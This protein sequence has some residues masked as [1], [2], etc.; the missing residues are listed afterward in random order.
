MFAKD[1]EEIVLLDQ[2]LAV[3]LERLQALG[4]GELGVSRSERSDRRWLVSVAPSDGPVAYYT[5]DRD[6]GDTTFMFHHREELTSYEL[7]PMEPF[8]FTARDGLE[9][10]GYVTFPLGC[11]GRTCPPC[12]T[13]TAG[14]GRA[15][16]GATTPRRSGSPT[17]AIS[18]SR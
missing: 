13:S 8:M 10:H 16:S 7:A 12:S 4:D 5:Y 14:R 17:A 11:R 2:S 9:V 1:R 18:A 15:T 3:D 6:S